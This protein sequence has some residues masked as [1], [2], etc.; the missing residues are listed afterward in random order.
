MRVHGQ[1]LMDERL[2]LIKQG[3]PVPEDILSY[4]IKCK[5]KSS[6]VGPSVFFPV[7]YVVVQLLIGVPSSVFCCRS[8]ESI[9]PPV[10]S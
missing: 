8:I 9:L 3:Q 7:P 10:G 1:K 4:V 6:S 5:G 2:Q